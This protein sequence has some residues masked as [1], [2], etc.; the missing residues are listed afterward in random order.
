MQQNSRPSV[1]DVESPERLDQLSG[2]K[3][4]IQGT[5]LEAALDEQRNILCAAHAMIFTTAHAL[6][7]E[8]GS[9]WPVIYPNFPS[10]LRQAAELVDQVSGDLEAGVIEDR[11]LAIARADEQEEIAN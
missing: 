4:S 9:D 11:G 8:F 5:P 3:G 10:V 2:Y 7:R 1:I 6:E